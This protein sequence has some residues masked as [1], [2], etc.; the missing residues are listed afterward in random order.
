MM[1]HLYAAL[2]QGAPIALN[3][4]PD[5]MAR[6]PDL[7]GHNQA[8]PH[9]AINQELAAKRQTWAQHVDLFCDWDDPRTPVPRTS[10]R[11]GPRDDRQRPRRL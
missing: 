8:V 9:S 2:W 7:A 6:H 1:Q 10:H 5:W 11:T 4:A 3:E